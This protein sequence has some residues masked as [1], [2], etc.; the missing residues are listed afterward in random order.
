MSTQN[1]L[2]GFRNYVPHYALIA[3][4]DTTARNQFFE[5]SS[6][7]PGGMNKY[8]HPPGGRDT[9]YTAQGEKQDY[10]VIFNSTTDAEFYI[11][12]LV[13]HSMLQAQ[14]QQVASGI[15][16]HSTGLSMEL[17]IVEPYTIDFM[18]TLV[19]AMFNLGI[20]HISSMTYIIK[21]FFIGYRD[22]D[23]T[24]EIISNVEPIPFVIMKTDLILTHAGT[25]YN[26]DCIP[27]AGLGNDIRFNNV[28]GVTM[29]AKGTISGCIDKLNSKLKDITDKAAKDTTSPQIKYQVI[30]DEAYTDS[31]YVIDNVTPSQLNKFDVATGTNNVQFITSKNTSLPQAITDIMLLSNAVVAESQVTAPAKG[32]TANIYSH[33]IYTTA[34]TKGNEVT[35]YYYVLRVNTI[36]TPEETADA[37]KAD[38]TTEKSDPLIVEAKKVSACLEYDYIY[39]GKNVDILQFV[40]SIPMV[41]NATPFTTIAPTNY[42]LSKNQVAATAN[43]TDPKKANVSITSGANDVTA[44]TVVNNPPINSTIAQPLTITDNSGTGKGAADAAMFYQGRNILSRYIM[45]YQMEAAIEIVGNPELLKTVIVPETVFIDAQG[46]P[47]SAS[48]VKTELTK[49]QEKGYLSGSALTTTV[50]KVN[51]RVPKPTYLQGDNYITGEVGESAPSDYENK[52]STKF[53]NDGVF[54]ITTME[55]VFEKNKFIQRM[56]LQKYS[57]SPTGTVSVVH[58]GTDSDTNSTKST[59]SDK[60]TTKSPIAAPG[61]AITTNTDQS[62]VRIYN[63]L[64]E[65]GVP[66][67]QAAGIVGNL[68]HESGLKTGAIGDGGTSAGLAQW[69]GSRNKDLQNFAASKGQLST[70]EDTQLDFMM[71]EFGGTEKGAY[72]KLMKTT[73][74]AEA[75]SV[76]ALNYERPAQGPTLHMDKRQAGAV[77]MAELANKLT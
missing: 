44:L 65:R 37:V 45:N 30:L 16:I 41:G 53:W 23:T 63:K 29:Q 67:V 4:K 74:P 31:K 71:H 33:K 62:N 61:K 1:P 27:T 5:T 18:S 6:N 75:A 73:T 77:G 10:V 12:R 28:G 50:L 42:A 59:P 76:F 20:G 24:V 9:R 58:T 72:N 46:N 57:S 54:T 11:D 60:L 35:Y 40:M 70:N 49:R 19:T 3:L 68:A 25:E 17:K 26:I 66:P 47:K 21:I 39:T 64:L 52:F 15:H 38:G 32:S 48:I 69:H 55:H 56:K 22:D 14:G 34:V 13:I 51:V 36:V 7:T 8:Q 2:H 43:Q